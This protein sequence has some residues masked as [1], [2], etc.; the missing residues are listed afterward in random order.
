MVLWFE[1]DLYD[2]LQLLDV[3]ALAHTRETAP[4]LIVIGSFDGKPEFA[5]LGELTASE[6]R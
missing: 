3:L 4:E 5:G 2:E 6:P 1:H